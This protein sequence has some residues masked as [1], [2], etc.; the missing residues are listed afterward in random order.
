MPTTLTLKNIPDEIYE[1]LKAAAK[2]HGRTMSDEAIMCLEI[3]LLQRRLV[4]QKG[5]PASA[6]FAQL[7]A[8]KMLI[9]V[10][11]TNSSAVIAINFI[12][13]VS[14]RQRE[15]I[16]CAWGIGIIKRP[17]KQVVTGWAWCT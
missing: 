4:H 12:S 5:L 6:L 14:A 3:F 2:V 11:W 9:I 15:N 8:V 10:L 16:F 1:R 7:Q 17:A 13:A